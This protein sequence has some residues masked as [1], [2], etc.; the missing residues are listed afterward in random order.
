[1][2]QFV[3]NNKTPNPKRINILG[4]SIIF[5]TLYG[6]IG[7]KVTKNRTER[8]SKTLYNVIALNQKSVAEPQPTLIWDFS[9]NRITGSAGC[10][11]Y[12]CDLVI[13]QSNLN[14]LIVDSII[15]TKIYCNSQVMATE[16]LFL[17]NL[18]KAKRW[19]QNRDTLFL[20]NAEG[21][22]ILVA[23]KT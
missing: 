5:I 7:S 23:V 3:H 19:V 16:Y 9:Q 14:A 17:D 15:T 1:M 12:S 20:S 18:K 22:S 4:A 21:Q 11:K 2:I 10:N 13:N 6:C 8:N